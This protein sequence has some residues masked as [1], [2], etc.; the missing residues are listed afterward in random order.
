MSSQ[1]VSSRRRFPN[2]WRTSTRPA[3]DCSE[4][5]RTSLPRV[6]SSAQW[7]VRSEHRYGAGCSKQQQ[8]Q[9]CGGGAHQIPSQLQIPPWSTSDPCLTHIR[10]QPNYSAQLPHPSPVHVAVSKHESTLVKCDAV[11]H[12][13]PLA[14]P[15]VHHHSQRLNGPRHPYANASRRVLNR[16]SDAVTHAEAQ[17]D[18]RLPSRARE[19]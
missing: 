12:G 16:T 1:V 17:L 15:L 7:A 18:K 19:R 6:R 3:G 5:S 2:R 11:R 14:L 13:C 9:V 10:S 4:R 8:Q